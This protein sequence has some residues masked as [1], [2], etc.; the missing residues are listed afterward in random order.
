MSTD[1]LKVEVNTPDKPEIFEIAAEVGMEPDLVF[2]KLFRVWSW[3]DQ[4]SAKGNAPV[5]L[6]SRIDNIAGA[7]GFAEAMKKSGWL[8][9]RKNEILIP[10]FDRHCGNPAKKR[11]LNARRQAK[12]R[13]AQGNEK[14]NAPNVTSASPRERERSSVTN[15]TADAPP[16]RPRK[17]IYDLG[18]PLLARTGI[19]EKRARQMIGKAIKVLGADEADRVIRTAEGKAEPAAWIEA[20]L[21]RGKLG[22]VPHDVDEMVRFASSNGLSGPRTGESGDQYRSRLIAE[23]Q[24]I[25]GER[26][27]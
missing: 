13:N 9:V 16:A 12:F 14:S 20:A 25:R 26:A 27:R 10:N 21:K 22:A 6:M 11:A 7:R 23:V 2:A 1:W 19:G 5:T 18:V 15:V 4:H 17:P 8:V 3:F 24:E